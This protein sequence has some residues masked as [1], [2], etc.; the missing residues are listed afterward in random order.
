MSSEI[1]KRKYQG[2]EEQIEE[3]FDVKTIILPFSLMSG[4]KEEYI[5]TGGE[6]LPFRKR[7]PEYKRL[8]MSEFAKDLEM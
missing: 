8:F 6:K 5:Y 7:H 3:N 2:L 1:K 4:K